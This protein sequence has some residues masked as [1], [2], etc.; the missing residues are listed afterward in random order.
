[1]T[2]RCRNPK[3]LVFK[4]YGGRGIKVCDEWDRDFL[5]FFKDMGPRPS[6]KHT[7]D[8]IDN[9]KGYCKSNC[10]WVTQQDQNNNRRSNKFFEI[11]GVRMTL[12]DIC[13]KFSIDYVAAKGRVRHGWAIDRVINTPVKK[14]H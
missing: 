7:I 3:S 13:R 10:R 2:Q 8:R 4:D 9:D 14:H 6:S 11:D 12:P 5:A 1:M